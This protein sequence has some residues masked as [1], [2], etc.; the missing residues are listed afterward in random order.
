MM[1]RTA[2]IVALFVVVEGRH[3]SCQFRVLEICVGEGHGEGI[4]FL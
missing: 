2:H 4:Y 1:V 3:V